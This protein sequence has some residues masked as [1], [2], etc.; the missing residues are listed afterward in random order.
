MK[1]SEIRELMN[2]ITQ[3]RRR[4]LRPYFL[5]LG[6]TVGQGQPRILRC[7]LANEGPMTQR[8]LADACYLDPTT[9]SRTLD[10]LQEAGLLFRQPH[11]DSRRAWLIDLTDAGREKAVKICARLAQWD[12]KLLTGFTQDELDSVRDALQCMLQNLKT[13]DESG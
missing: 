6:L 7:L 2:E 9:M 3:I 5:S 1:K 12:E 13:E 11:P 10:H 8:A 4:E